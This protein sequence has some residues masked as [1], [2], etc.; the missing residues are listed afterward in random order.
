MAW[1]LGHMGE[2]AVG[3]FANRRFGDGALTTG[4][5]AFAPTTADVTAFLYEHYRN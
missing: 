1:R 5:I 2:M 4:Q 3:G